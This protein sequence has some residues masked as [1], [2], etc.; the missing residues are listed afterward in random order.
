MRLG[1][2]I[3]KISNAI[4]CNP[5]CAAYN[6]CRGSLHRR[7]NNFNEA[8]D[9]LLLA[10]DKCDSCECE[11]YK[12]AQKQLLITYNDFAVYCYDRVW[13]FAVIQLI[14]NSYTLTVLY[15]NRGFIN[16]AVYVLFGN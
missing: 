8:V 15:P 16:F 2:A 6:V 4:E 7:V 13:V 1:D 3:L 9:D 14:D 12:Q 11:D 10:L 5:T